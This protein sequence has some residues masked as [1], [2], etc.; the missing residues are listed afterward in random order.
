MSFHDI[1][2]YEFSVDL[3]VGD[4]VKIWRLFE[5]GGTSKGVRAKQNAS[6]RSDGFSGDDVRLFR[7]IY[8]QSDNKIAFVEN[9]EHKLDQS[10]HKLVVDSEEQ[11][12]SNSQL[13]DNH[14]CVDDHGGNWEVGV[15]NESDGL[16]DGLEA[17][18][19]DMAKSLGE[20]SGYHERGNT[21]FMGDSEGYSYKVFMCGNA[22]DLELVLNNNMFLSYELQ[23]MNSDEILCVLKMSK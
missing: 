1:N 20:T 12:E 10:H 17:R 13:Y 7:L 18:F 6:L 14:E 22:R 5:H 8:N 21:D 15:E 4:V 3:S 19:I 23:I 16:D 9:I 2:N 11:G